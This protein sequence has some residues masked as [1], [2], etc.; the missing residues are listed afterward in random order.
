MAYKKSL[1][2]FNP[3]KNT[4]YV[5]ASYFEERFYKSKYLNRINKKTNEIKLSFLPLLN[6][7]STSK[8]DRILPGSNAIIT[9]GQLK[10]KFIVLPPNTYFEREFSID[11][12]T[13]IRFSKDFNLS[14]LNM[15]DTLNFKDRKKCS[16][17]DF[18]KKIIE[19]A[20]YRNIKNLCNGNYFFNNPQE[21]NN[22]AK[23]Y[24][25]YKL[26]IS[27]TGS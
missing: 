21:Y 26:E 25:V 8:S 22:V 13:P 16:K 23:G 10:Y 24:K 4:L 6:N 27:P 19:F 18:F 14:R 17:T 15:S 9:R 1:N 20:L 2:H 11:Y 12:S 5:F 7:L 3:T